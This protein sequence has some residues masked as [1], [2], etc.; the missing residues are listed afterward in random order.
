M[1]TSMTPAR[2]AIMSKNSSKSLQNPF[3]DRP[4]F[5][6]ASSIRIHARRV[7]P[8]PTLR[9][10]SANLRLLFFAPLCKSGATGGFELRLMP[11]RGGRKGGRALLDSCPLQHLGDHLH[12]EVE[13]IVLWFNPSHSSSTSIWICLI[14][15]SFKCLNLPCFKRY[16]W[17]GRQRGS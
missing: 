13:R 2:A 4:L 17:T 16:S 5:S 9:G 6:E 1:N 14:C 7:Y 3:S 15:S 11:P 12:P 10:G 8:L